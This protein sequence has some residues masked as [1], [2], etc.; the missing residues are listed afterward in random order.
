MGDHLKKRRYELGLRQKDVAEQLD[1]NEFTVCGWENDKKTPAVRY[2]P[3]IVEFLGYCPFPAPETLGERLL[4]K[5]RS[6]G[7]SRKRMG[8]RLSVDEETFARWE[9]G[10]ASPTGERL[11]RAEA[12]LTTSQPSA[13]TGDK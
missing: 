9:N 7:L 13:L 1:V 10:E 11:R 8:Q 4:A 12:F 5:R 6:L 2:L 3:R